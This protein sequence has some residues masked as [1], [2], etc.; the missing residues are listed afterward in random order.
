MDPTMDAATHQERLQQREPP[1]PL[2]QSIL[3]DILILVGKILAI[4]LVFLALFTWLFGLFRNSDPFM[5][6]A[7]KD[8]DLVFFYRLDKDYSAQDILVLEVEGRKQ[9]RRVVATAG[10]QVDVT[11]EG[12]I[13]NGA[14]QQEPAIFYPTYR[15]EQ[16]IAFPVTLSEGEV[17]VLGDYRTNAEDSRLYGVVHSEKTLGK[18][19]SIFRRRGI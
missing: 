17:F 12:L 13:I 19:M 11:E 8:G 6:P 2:Y 16:G 10:D 3:L 14:I 9:V 4:V 5:A 1:P 7:I 15:Y 18:V